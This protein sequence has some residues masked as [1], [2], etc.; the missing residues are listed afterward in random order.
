M[1]TTD[2]EESAIDAV[3]LGVGE[4]GSIG[5]GSDASDRR[6]RLVPLPFTKGDEGVGLR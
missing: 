3:W 4:G 1:V 2:A 6:M 5:S